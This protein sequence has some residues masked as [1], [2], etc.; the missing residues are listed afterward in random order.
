MKNKAFELRERLASGKIVRIMGAHNGLGARLI[1][2]HHFDA[3]WASGLEISTAYG[4]PD[5]NILTMTENLEAARAINEATC[6]PVVCDC[7]TGYGN[8]TQVMHMVRR[9]E[10]AGI[11]AVVIEDKCFPKINSLLAA[12][13]ELVSLEE[14]AG[15][16][17][18]A[19]QA[20]SN[21]DFLV[22][23]RV[24]ALI[25]GLG[26]EEALRRANAYADA[27]ADAVVIHS[28]AKTPEEIFL[29]AKEWKRP[30]PLVAIPTTYFKVTAPELEKAGF[31]MVIYANQGLRA[32]IRAMQGVFDQI[33]RE[34][35]S[36]SVE[37][38]IAT[39]GEVFE[40]QGMQDMQQDEERF[41]RGE[42]IQAVIPA[43][44]DHRFQPDL[45]GHLKDTPLCMLDIG[46]RSLLERQMDLLSSAG[47][48]EVF[49][50]GGHLH[51]RI[52]ASGA[53]VLY[54]PGYQQC[55]CAGSILFARDRMKENTL[56]LYSDILF[57]RRILTL[58]LQSPHPV[59]LVIDRAYRSLP[60][61]QKPLDLVFADSS[62]RGDARRLDL[63]VFKPIR[64]IG[65]NIR[66]GEPTHEFIG[67]A[68]L[69][70]QGVRELGR[71]WDEALTRFSGRPFYEAPAPEKADFTDLARFLLDRGCPVYGME[72][73]QGWS[74]I[75]SLEDYLRIQSHY[76]SKDRLPV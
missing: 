67:M 30:V 69:R 41:V 16:I 25:A 55:Q 43:A 34:G 72:I 46:G 56:I 38:G 71:A 70:G 45:A 9:Y 76:T 24:E 27:G 14:F 35:T 21:P 73:E 12:R 59:T 51:D 3:V 22:I 31:S 48:G 40:L 11:A 44:R 64:D 8:A 60:S 75:H 20:R 61:R 32:S 47:V 37:A 74:E 6:L 68:L 36:A 28:K 63:D 29:F 4:L 50:V 54:N 19:C 33:D 49:V 10:A 42:S 65:K 66:L 18:A 23:A 5:A 26:Q 7:D 15:K 62:S 52:Q 39:L 17:Q 13:Q 53:Q 58:L 1:E 57:D 2:R